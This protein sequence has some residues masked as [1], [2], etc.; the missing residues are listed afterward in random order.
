MS[1]GVRKSYQRASLAFYFGSRASDD[2][3][4]AD[5]TAQ[6]VMTKFFQWA[7]NGL[8]WRFGARNEEG[9]L[10][11]DAIEWSTSTDRFANSL[12]PY[13]ACDIERVSTRRAVWQYRDGNRW[14]IARKWYRAAVPQSLKMYGRNGKH[15]GIEVHFV[16]RDGVPTQVSWWRLGLAWG[17]ELSRTS[18]HQWTICERHTHHEVCIRTGQ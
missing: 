1:T 2:R 4:Y 15:H 3:W 11:G 14:G 6:G 5:F 8:P 17:P 7:S 9:H 10:N 12:L 13:V 16:S 18:N